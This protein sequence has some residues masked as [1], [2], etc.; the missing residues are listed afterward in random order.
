MYILSSFLQLSFPGRKIKISFLEKLNGKDLGPKDTRHCEV[1]AENE[2]ELQVGIVT[3]G[4]PSDPY[5]VPRTVKASIEP[6]PNLQERLDI[7]I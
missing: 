6:T 4:I 2:D 7:H 3:G 5:F 1:V